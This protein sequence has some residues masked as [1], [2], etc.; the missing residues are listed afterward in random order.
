MCSIGIEPRIETA[1]LV[2]RAPTA[3]DAPRLAPLIDDF[4][5]ARMTTR[6]PHPYGL[7]DAEAFLAGQQAIDGGIDRTLHVETQAGELIGAVGAHLRDGPFPEI[8]YWIAREHWGRGY[9]TEAAAAIRDWARR[10]FGCR[11]IVAG[12]FAD[13][14]ASGRVLEKCGF[15]YTGAVQQRFSLARGDEAATRMMVWLA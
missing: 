6:I 15:L 9:A 11:A 10:M 13:N 14:P 8:G 2:L 5:I 4:D 12:H 1:R 3:S 7:A